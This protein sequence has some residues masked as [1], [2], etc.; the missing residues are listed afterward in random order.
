MSTSPSTEG[1]SRS[2]RDA[3]RPPQRNFSASTQ[4]LP[5]P[6]GL[7]T[8]SCARLSRAWTLTR[9]RTSWF[10]GVRREQTVLASSEAAPRSWA[11]WSDG[12]GVAHGGQ[13]GGCPGSASRRA[14]WRDGQTLL[15]QFFFQFFYDQPDPGATHPA[16]LSLR[17]ANAPCSTHTRLPWHAVNKTLPA[18]R[19][20]EGGGVRKRCEKAGPVL[21]RALGVACEALVPVAAAASSCRR[22]C[23]D[24]ACALRHR[25][26]AKSPRAAQ[27]RRRMPPPRHSPRS[28]LPSCLTKSTHNPFGF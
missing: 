21:V 27:K 8:C 16:S 18:S 5:C 12:V 1:A 3:Q 22:A 25:S 26:L 13:P 4:A 6:W 19:G 23:Q 11:G 14:R 9:A 20:L 10:P 24:H 7:I 15:D 2:G 17:T 28:P